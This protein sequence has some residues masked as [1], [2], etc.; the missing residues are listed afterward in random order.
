MMTAHHRLPLVF[1][2]DEVATTNRVDGKTIT[3]A[4]FP[5]TGKE[6]IEMKVRLVDVSL[7]VRFLKFNIVYMN[8]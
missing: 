8:N 5:V 4:R 3:R 2:A 7:D 6:R 1:L